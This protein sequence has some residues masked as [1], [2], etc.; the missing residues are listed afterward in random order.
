MK[1]VKS[2][3]FQMRLRQ[4]KDSSKRRSNRIEGLQSSL[5]HYELTGGGKQNSDYR[6]QPKSRSQERPRSEGSQIFFLLP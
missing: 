2:S 4:K 3:A 6:K 1:Q 5:S